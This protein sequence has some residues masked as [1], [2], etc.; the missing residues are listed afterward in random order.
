MCRCGRRYWSICSI[1]DLFG[2]AEKIKE[3]P[4]YIGHRKRLREKF[5]KQ[6]K[7]LADYELLEVMQFASSA[8]FDTKLL[9]K[10]FIAKFGSLAK[11]LTA[12]VSAL[13]K[14]DGVNE[15]TI[16]AIKVVQKATSRL[17]LS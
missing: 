8:R 2:A 15:A 17:L 13:G 9:A 4:Y 5:L 10:E 7:S 12:D 14:V 16:A 6:P 11:V 1:A 3:V